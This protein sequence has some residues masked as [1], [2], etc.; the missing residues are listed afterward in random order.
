MPIWDW[1]GV[2]WKDDKRV[3]MKHVSLGKSGL[4]IKQIGLI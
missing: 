4:W 2:K 1:L 3:G